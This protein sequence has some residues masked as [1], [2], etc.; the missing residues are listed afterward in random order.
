MTRMTPKLFFL[1]L[2]LLLV[3]CGCV[4]TL[5]LKEVMEG[6]DDWIRELTQG[7]TITVQHPE[8][9]VRLRQPYDLVITI[10]NHGKHEPHLNTA[11]VSLFEGPNEGLTCTMVEP[12]PL[13]TQP[14]GS[15]VLFYMPPKQ[16]ARNAPAT[17][18][19]IQCTFT[20]PAT[21]KLHFGAE[22]RESGHAFVSR[23]FVVTAR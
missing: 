23:V 15:G 4:N 1:A 18:I 5:E 6:S 11:I 21:Y 13:E 3:G 17:T 12:K 10:E 8:G 9:E 16:I 19:R 7:M 22:F 20:Q 2:A 14:F